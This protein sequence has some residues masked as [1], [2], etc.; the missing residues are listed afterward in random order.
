MFSQQKG[1]CLLQRHSG[2]L[3]PQEK[4]KPE[5]TEKT[6]LSKTRDTS[7]PEETKHNGKDSRSGTTRFLATRQR[8]TEGR[9]VENG[10]VTQEAYRRSKHETDFTNKVG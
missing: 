5:I 3:E 6:Q 2:P 10:E 1:R 8:C 9:R 4:L 7:G